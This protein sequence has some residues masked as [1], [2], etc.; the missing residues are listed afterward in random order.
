[1]PFE[2]WSGKVNVNKYTVVYN[3]IVKNK[4]I[5]WCEI[6]HRLPTEYSR[7]S[8]TETVC[9]CVISIL[10]YS[11]SKCAQ[12]EFNLAWG[13]KNTFYFKKNWFFFLFM[14]RPWHHSL[15]TYTKSCWEIV[16]ATIKHGCEQDK[17]WCKIF[18]D[19][20]SSYWAASLSQHLTYQF[21]LVH[22][23]SACVKQGPKAR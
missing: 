8:L 12:D 23:W 19:Y 6:D 9:F 4:Y 13:E 3:K 17:T 15:P 14:M 21:I 5:K 18:Q 20:T 11:L 22:Y 7:D 16:S 10:P 1:M 2:I